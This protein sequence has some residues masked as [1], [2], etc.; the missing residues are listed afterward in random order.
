[1]AIKLEQGSTP[2]KSFKLNGLDYQ[3]GA[4]EIIYRDQGSLNPQVG[5]R[6][7]TTNEILQNPSPFTEW[8]N[9]ADTPYGSFAVLVSDITA[10]VF[11]DGGGNGGGV[12]VG[13]TVANYSL[14]ADGAADGE[15]AYVQT[16]EGTAWLPST[17]G[18]T[19]YP[20]GIYLWAGGEWT[21]DRN[22]I[23]NQLE[24]SKRNSEIRVTQQNK[25]TT[26]GGTIDS[27]KIYFL[28][29]II[30][31][32]STQITVPATGISIKGDSFDISGLISSQNNYTMFISATVGG[33]GGGSGNVL[34]ADY[35]ISILGAGSK[36]Y[37]IYDDTG[38]NAFEFARINYIDCTDL[39]DIYN[40][41]Q[42]LEEGTGRFG[43]SPSL[44]LH[45]LWRGGYRITT[46]IVRGLSGMMTKPLFKEG[47][48][49][50]M[51]SRFLTDINCDLPTLAPFCDF[52]TF[53]FPNP[54]T[55]QLKGAIFTRDDAFNP[56]DTNILPNLTASDLACDWDNNVG[57]PNTFVGGALNNE[58]E[59]QTVIV[60]QGEAVDL[61]GTFAT[62][63]LQ[64]FDSPANGR[65]RHIGI[66]P[67]EFIVNW[68]FLIDGKDNDNY[69]LF[70]IKIDTQ[71]NVTVEYAQVRT[72]NNFQG[73]RD[74]GIWSGQTSVIL[75]QNDIVFW[76]IA[77]LLD[78]DNCTLEQDSS[79]SVKE[80]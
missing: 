80:R 14:L 58:T 40:Y 47:L 16:S 36:V 32:G 21:S 22:A 63:D 23:A 44:T 78:N 61:N 26:L 72:V 52:K 57:I 28:D 41:R 76:Q 5:L 48:I 2:T 4:Y 7:V 6:N 70:L 38:F 46:S 53:N 25:D 19:Y 15:L 30:D 9:G 67:R 55:V 34:G 56:S 1:M 75:N 51:N 18:G 54:S 50:Q 68:D 42:G 59:V 33:D 60:N 11:K 39:G 77:N 12:T 13:Q 29:G 17:L 71:A 64:H 35:F 73:G 37:E 62:I 43:G 49:F 3:Q 10:K 66:N 20:A 69:E 31:M 8:V 45:G 74:V 65:L 27:T 79:W 24:R